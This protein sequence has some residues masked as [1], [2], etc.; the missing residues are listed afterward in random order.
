MFCFRVCFRAMMNK[1]TGVCS[2]KA[3]FVQHVHKKNENI[4][5]KSIK[6]EQRGNRNTE[7]ASRLF[8]TKKAFGLSSLNETGI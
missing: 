1:H 6:C 2:P 8:C 5:S 3:L 4:N 7:S